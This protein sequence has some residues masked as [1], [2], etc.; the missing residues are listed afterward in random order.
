MEK[1]GRSVKSLLKRTLKR[2]YAFDKYVFFEIWRRRCRVIRIGS[3]TS[4]RVQAERMSNNGET[5]KNAYTRGK[6]HLDE[7]NNKAGKSLMWRKCQERH[8]NEL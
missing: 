3:I 5:L 7:Y 6:Q 1:T 8:K 2:R 4:S